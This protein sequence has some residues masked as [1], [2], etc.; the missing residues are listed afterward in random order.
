MSDENRFRPFARHLSRDSSFSGRVVPYVLLN[1]TSE[2]V[3]LLFGEHVDVSSSDEASLASA[4]ESGKPVRIKDLDLTPSSSVDA[5]TR[6]LA[7][8]VITVA[9]MSFKTGKGDKDRIKKAMAVLDPRIVPFVAATDISELGL[10]YSMLFQDTVAPDVQKDKFQKNWWEMAPTYTWTF[11]KV[12]DK[13]LADLKTFHGSEEEIEAFGLNLTQRVEKAKAADMERAATPIEMAKTGARHEFR[14]WFLGKMGL[15]GMSTDQVMS[16]EGPAVRERNAAFRAVF[17]YS[18]LVRD[19][20]GSIE[21]IPT[22]D[23]ESTLKL[24]EAFQAAHSGG[25]ADTGPS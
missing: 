3:D 22:P 7:S 18:Q 8:D 10:C 17:D 16:Y 20:E 14:S 4:M 9:T 2:D 21:D 13:C 6:L 11:F 19:H 24:V 1:L 5:V 25:K 12:V 15:S 23:F